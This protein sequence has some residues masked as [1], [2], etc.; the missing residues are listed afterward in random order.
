MILKFL[1]IEGLVTSLQEYKENK[2]YTPID[3]VQLLF[4]ISIF[5][6]KFPKLEIF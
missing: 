1:V 6:I 2:K 3:E 4:L 5:K